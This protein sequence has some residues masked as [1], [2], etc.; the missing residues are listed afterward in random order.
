MELLR[1]LTVPNVLDLAFGFTLML[2]TNGAATSW[3]VRCHDVFVS[4]GVNVSLNLEACK[5]RNMIEERAG[6]K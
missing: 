4:Y 1:I 3:W 6:L 5:D 2:H